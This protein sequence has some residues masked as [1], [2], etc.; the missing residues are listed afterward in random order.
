MSNPYTVYI[1]DNFHHGDASAR[2]RGREY[3]TLAEAIQ[4]CQQIVD[5]WLEDAMRQGVEPKDLYDSYRAFGDDPWVSS[6]DVSGVPFSAWKYAEQRCLELV[7]A[8]G[9]ASKLN[10]DIE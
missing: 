5:G 10:G 2:S 8:R 3:A 1:D 9:A 4:R 6:A 7:A